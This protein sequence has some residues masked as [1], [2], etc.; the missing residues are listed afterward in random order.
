MSDI[1]FCFSLM[2]DEFVLPTDLS[3]EGCLTHIQTIPVPIQ[4]G[5]L[6][7]HLV[8]T[9]AMVYGHCGACIQQQQW[10]T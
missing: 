5:A 6:G 4:P 9:T 2:T 10:K 7:K 1:F 8:V 3:L